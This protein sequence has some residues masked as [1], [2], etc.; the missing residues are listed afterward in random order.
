MQSLQAATTRIRPSGF[1]HNRTT[2]LQSEQ[3]F[4][5][6]RCAATD[7]HV[8][9]FPLISGLHIGRFLN[10]CAL[11]IQ[12]RSLQIAA[13]RQI[14]SQSLTFAGRDSESA[15]PC[16]QRLTFRDDFDRPAGHHCCRDFVNFMPAN[17]DRRGCWLG[18][19]AI[20][21]ISVLFHEFEFTNING[22]SGFALR[23]CSDR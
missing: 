6:G 20:G 4:L 12:Q 3:E 5:I 22:F 13:K 16:R 1:I 9:R 23:I 18:E 11:V 19:I 17:P 2:E 21:Q 14:D 8:I 15:T 10:R 7:V